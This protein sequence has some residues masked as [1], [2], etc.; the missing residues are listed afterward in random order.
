MTG[1]EKLKSTC[2]KCK[3]QKWAVDF[4]EGSY[5]KLSSTSICLSCEQGALIEAQKKEID[6]LKAKEKENDKKITCLEEYIQKIEKLLNE[7]VKTQASSGD[8]SMSIPSENSDAQTM[9]CKIDK[10]S[11]IVKENRDEI[12]E[13]GKEV[14]EIRAKIASF[15]NEVDFRTVRG[16]RSVRARDDKQVITLSNRFAILEDQVDNTIEEKDDEVDD[17]LQI[18]SYVIGDS[19]VREQ[20]HHFAMKNR[21][22]RKNR[23]VKSFPG[24]KAKKIV[25]EVNE[26]CLESKSCCI[27]ANAG[28]N[29][30]F[31]KGNKVGNSESLIKELSSLVDSLAGKTENGILLGILPRRYVSHYAM[32]KAIGINE[33]I[34]EYCQKKGV[35]FV[36][37]WKIFFGKWH[38][39]KRD[40]IHLNAIG[41]RKLG[42]IFF[43]AFN[44][45]MNRGN[46]PSKPLQLTPVEV[47]ASKEENVENNEFEG[48]PNAQPLEG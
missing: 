21:R 48:F 38:F 19:I 44:G 20:V 46:Q 7:G 25:D 12:V 33:R 35:D 6:M 11:K 15:K 24:C 39:F 28:S 9:N 31:G 8:L 18:D 26:I 30:L 45:R 10:L 5:S 1:P 29:D 34:H 42:E 17:P 47:Q 13:T 14:V 16:K 36:D 22:Q 2:F 4:K 3:I 43:H 41:H 32:S 40:G 23:I 27:I 37:P